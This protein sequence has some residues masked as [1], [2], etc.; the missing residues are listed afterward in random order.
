MLECD[1]CDNICPKKD[2]LLM[3]KGVKHK[4]KLSNCD[5]CDFSCTKSKVPVM[6]KFRN[7]GGQELSRKLFELCDFTCLI[8]GGLR[9]HQN[10][11]RS[12]LK[13]P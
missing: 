8:T 12:G 7:H 3:H 10:A 11:E 6:H 4:A 5:E 13:G 9:F 2:T 1:S